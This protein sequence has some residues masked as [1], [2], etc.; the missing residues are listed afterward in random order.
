VIKEIR[1]EGEDQKWEAVWWGGAAGSGVEAQ[2]SRRRL[3]RRWMGEEEE[4][5]TR[6]SAE[7]I[8][9]PAQQGSLLIVPI[10]LFDGKLITKLRNLRVI[11]TTA[12]TELHH[13][14]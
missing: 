11:A 12:R 14:L 2:W 1:E 5:V 3:A 13:A 7:S 8:L 6:T 9:G 4:A 10:I